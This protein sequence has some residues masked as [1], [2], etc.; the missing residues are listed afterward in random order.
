MSA[1]AEQHCLNDSNTNSFQR[2][3][4]KDAENAEENKNW[5]RIASLC[6]L[7]VSA[8]SALKA[9]NELSVSCPR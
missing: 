9:V 7:C 3:G 8:L 2:R 4:R 1:L 6:A 5:H